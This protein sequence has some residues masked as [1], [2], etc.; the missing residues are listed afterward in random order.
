MR[1]RRLTALIVALVFAGGLTLRIWMACGQAGTLDSDMA[2]LGLMA[3]N[4]QDGQ[5]EVFHW[6]QFYGGAQE[7]YL[8]ALFGLIGGVHTHTL[9]ITTIFLSACVAILIGLVANEL[10]G[11]RT[12]WLSAGLF[13][14]WP[15]PFVWW[16]TKIGSNYWYALVVA[17]GTCLVLLQLRKGN[18]TTPRL[19][20]LG[21]LLGQCL[22][23][24]PQSGYV[25]VPAL[26]YCAAA[27][28]KLRMRLIY[29]AV[30]GVVS[31]LPWW[32]VF[33]MTK[34]MPLKPPGDEL[35]AWPDGLLTTI[36]YTLPMVLSFRVP[37]SG[38]WVGGP[39]FGVIGCLV[40][41]AGIA[42]A[43]IRAKDKPMFAFL[44]FLG[45]LLLFV[46]Q[47]WSL[48]GVQPRY[49]LWFSP[50]LVILVAALL[51]K[52]PRKQFSTITFALACAAFL[53]GTAALSSIN[54][55][56][57][58]NTDRI[59]QLGPDKFVPKDDSD[60][61]ALLHENNSK[62]FY[63]DYWL[64]YRVTFETNGKLVGSPDY[65]PRWEPFEKAVAASGNPPHVFMAGSKMIDQFQTYCAE[66]QMT[67]EVKTK[68]DFALMNTSR[69]LTEQEV[70][71]KFLKL[72]RLQ[73]LQSRPY[74]F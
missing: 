44:A 9:Y 68:G 52:T 37:G 33:V 10:Y 49:L 42:I 73:P 31:S 40:V 56:M 15:A 69:L 24:N 71:S 8:A 36:K 50:W 51:I 58:N 14:L 18:R 17:L 59:L 32:V 4:V 67:C 7:T 72:K 39:A 35:D 23:A 3:R 30:A 20:L 38:D 63:G 46:T 11:K 74:N 26:I 19:L 27:L 6:G 22:W 41:I 64:A 25:L 54:L 55:A 5:F 34:G 62:Y 57:L 29:V 47:Q 12:G 13:W 2:V 45:S 53:A 66:Q 28:L 65:T 70:T 60:L 1:T 48:F 61:I 16:A 21:F 43:M